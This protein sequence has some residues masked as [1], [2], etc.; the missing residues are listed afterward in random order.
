MKPSLILFDAGGTLLTPN[1]SVGAIYFSL[2]QKHGLDRTSETLEKRFITAFK[3]IRK[4]WTYPLYYGRTLKQ[5]RF[6]WREVLRKTLFSNPEI[7][8][9]QTNQSKQDSFEKLFLEIFEYFAHKEAWQ[10]YSD[11][12]A[13]L[14]RLKEKRYSLGI[15][16]N[17]DARLLNILKEMQVLELWDYFFISYQMGIEKPDPKLF[18]R[19]IERSKRKPEEILF[20]GNDYS[21][22]YLPAKALGIPCLLI[23]R[24]KSRVFDTFSEISSSELF[25]VTN[26][27]TTYRIASLEELFPYLNII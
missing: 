18:E 1:P 9:I 22:D 16:S 26:T 21:E 5:S 6:F 15:L 13:T 8:E 3:D 23:R 14:Y 20:I 27:D 24:D 12:Q 4:N 2:A 19:V 17:W 7:L 10:F 25:S 11:V